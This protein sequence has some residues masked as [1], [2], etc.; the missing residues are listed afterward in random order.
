MDTADRSP[1]AG[2]HAPGT[3]W[4]SPTCP[5]CGKLVFPWLIERHR[6]RHALLRAAGVLFL[7]ICVAD[8]L[9]DVLEMIRGVSP[10]R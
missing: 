5:H 10:F 4:I 8:V 7:I 9:W 3:G 1:T 2:E 6:K